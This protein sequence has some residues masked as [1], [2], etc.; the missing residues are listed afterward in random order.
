MIQ[1]TLHFDEKKSIY[2]WRVYLIFFFFIY[3]FLSIFEMFEIRHKFMK[4]NDMII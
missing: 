1:F 3:I 2:I 4:I